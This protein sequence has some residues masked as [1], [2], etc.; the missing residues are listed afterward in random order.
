MF[1]TETAM[2]TGATLEAVRMPQLSLSG[3]WKWLH[4]NPLDT[5]DQQGG[6]ARGKSHHASADATSLEGG[7]GRKPGKGKGELPPFERETDRPGTSKTGAARGDAKSFDARTSK[8]DAR[9]STATSD[10][11]VNADG[12]TTV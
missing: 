11:Y 8:R 3:L 10:F 7:A 9:R 6:T 4:E 5:P 1:T 12:S 2:A